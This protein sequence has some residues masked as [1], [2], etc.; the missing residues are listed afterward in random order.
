[1]SCEMKDDGSYDHTQDDDELYDDPVKQDEPITDTGDVGDCMIDVGSSSHQKETVKMKNDLRDTATTF[2]SNMFAE[3]AEISKYKFERAKA[4]EWATRDLC[5]LVYDDSDVKIDGFDSD[6]EEAQHE[7][8]LQMSLGDSSIPETKKTEDAEPSE[9]IDDSTKAKCR[10]CASYPEFPHKWKPR[11]FRL[12]NPTLDQPARYSADIAYS[13]T[14]R[15]YVAVSYCWPPRDENPIPRSYTVRDLDG[16]VRTI[17]ALDDVLDRAVD[18]ASS[19]GLRMIW[20]DQECLPQPTETSSKADWEVQELGIQSMDIVYNKAMYTAG[21]LNVEIRSQEQLNAI[22]T[23]LRSDWQTVHRT[24]NRQYCKH[25]MD[26]LHETSQDRWY[27][28]A[29]VIQEAICAGLKLMLAF[30][31]SPGLSYSQKFRYGY[32]AERDHRPHHSLDD[33]ERGL[34]ST[35]VCMTL[36]EFWR[37]L[38]VMQN[39][40]TRDFSVMGSMLVHFG[41]SPPELYPGARSVL[42]AAQRLHPRTVRANS[43]FMNITMYTE[44]AY[45]KRPTI[46]AAGALTLLKDRECYFESDRLAIIAN[47]CDYDFRLDTKAIND[48]CPSLRLAILALALNNSDLSLLAP[49]TYPPPNKTYTGDAYAGHTSSSLLFQSFSLEAAKIDNCQ[50]RDFF[51]TRFQST[52]PGSVTSDG[53]LLRAY[54]WSVDREIDFT[55]IQSTWSDAWESLRCWKIVVERQ[56]SE[57]WEQFH[58]RQAA[59]AQ[60]LSSPGVSTRALEDYRRFGNIPD[61]SDVWGSVD[62]RGVQVGRFV[63]PQRFEV[64]E[65]RDL[66]TRV[67]F[68]ILRFTLTISEEGNLAQ[69]LANSI[70]HSIRIDQVPGSQHELPDEVGDT[71]FSHIDVLT[72]PFAT[73]QL[74]E[75]PDRSLAQ[76]WFVDRIMEKGSLWCGTYIPPTRQDGS[77][78]HFSHGSTF[79]RGKGLELGSAFG[80]WNAP[81][82]KSGTILY[83][84]MR[85]QLLFGMLNSKPSESL[86]LSWRR[87][88]M[89][90]CEVLSND[91]YWTA[92]GQ[93]RRKETLLS[94]FDVNGPCQVATP[95]NAEWEILPRPRLRNMSVCWVVEGRKSK[96]RAATTTAEKDDAPDDAPEDVS[97]L[98]LPSEAK[99]KGKRRASDLPRDAEISKNTDTLDTSELSSNQ[100]LDLRVLRKVKGL[101]QLMDLPSQDYVFS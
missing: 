93:K 24:M 28:R 48:N 45:G 17:R 55:P 8:A 31:R 38:D 37:I 56:K 62:S 12:V 13:D 79:P 50:V 63:D 57:T 4:R 15:H 71:L 75:T 89:A 78:M 49:E 51:T 9:K 58:A 74:E 47:M 98:E 41:S 68:D 72:R 23:L 27:T 43:P 44:G 92:R 81:K 90:H 80:K 60:R 39:L 69:G 40:L 77:I 83:R 70:W 52:T 61:D 3:I 84:Q 33:H 20:I 7:Y 14:C 16:R 54:L 34:D 18:F 21:L 67:I 32:E 10:V 42:Q 86:P 53:L 35:L 5:F 11:K 88:M 76:L 87:P 82:V 25:V 46:N 1:M 65:M 96:G 64:P 101:W 26:F 59:I 99:G 6:D 36:N 91:D 29:W 97:R 73:L 66:I 100:G 95:F 2:G 22:E 85:R 19:C 30:R 94:T